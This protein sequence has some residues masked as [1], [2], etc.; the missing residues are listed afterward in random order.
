MVTLF[1]IISSLIDGVRE[2]NI[3]GLEAVF[4]LQPV[5]H[6]QCVDVVDDSVGYRVIALYN[7]GT[8]VYPN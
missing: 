1:F 7:P 5:G 2:T 3:V 6:Q 8:V 4:V